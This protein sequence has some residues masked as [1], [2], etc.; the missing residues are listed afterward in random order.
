MCF[1]CLPQSRSGQCVYARICSRLDE[2]EIMLLTHK[3]QLCYSIQDAG[4][5]DCFYRYA[6]EGVTFTLCGN[7]RVRYTAWNSRRCL[8]TYT[9]PQRHSLL[10]IRAFLLSLCIYDLIHSTLVIV[11]FEQG[12]ASLLHTCARRV[13]QCAWYVAITCVAGVKISVLVLHLSLPATENSFLAFQLHDS[14]S[15]AAICS[16]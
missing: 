14:S 8:W 1:L 3:L 9:H 11:Q 12:A 15:S 6:Q 10:R 2:R 5:R 16:Q 13:E 7:T 4:N